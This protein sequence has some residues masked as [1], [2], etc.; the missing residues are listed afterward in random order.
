MGSSAIHGSSS[1]ISEEDSSYFDGIAKELKWL[2]KDNCYKSM[3]SFF[4]C[5]FFLFF[6]SSDMSTATMRFLS[7]LDSG[8]LEESY[9]QSMT[10]D[11]VRL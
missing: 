1:H 9:R 5:Q 7:G 8:K 4:F 2:P 11:E 10:V 3:G 6:L